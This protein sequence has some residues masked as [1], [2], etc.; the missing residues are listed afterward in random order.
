MS[1]RQ[2]HLTRRTTLINLGARVWRFGNRLG[3]SSFI[4][5]N[6]TNFRSGISRPLHDILP[7]SKRHATFCV[8]QCVLVRHNS[9]RSPQDHQRYDTPQQ[10]ASYWTTYAFLKSKNNNNNKPVVDELEG[11]NLGKTKHGGG[12]PVALAQQPH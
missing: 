1:T 10:R 6:R 11:R 12:R 8:F 5:T 9:I 2:L 7:D 4:R 3:K